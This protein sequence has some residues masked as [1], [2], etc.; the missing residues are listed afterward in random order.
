MTD[1]GEL[2]VRIKADAAQLEQEMKKANGVVRQSAGEMGDVMG[3]LKNQF[4]D[5]IPAITIAAV[6]EFGR[7]AIESAD[8]I[9]DLALRTGFAGSTLSALNIPLKQSGSSLDDFSASINRMNNLIGEAAKGTNQEAVKAFDSLGL[10]VRKLRQLSPEDQFFAIAQALG[11]M[12]DQSTMTNAGMAIFGRSFS[13]IIP[14][15]KEAGGNLRDFVEKAEAAGNTL[16]KEQLDRID[17]FGDKWTEAVEKAKLAV[18]EFTPV[19]E[20]VVKILDWVNQQHPL[21]AL[22]AAGIEIGAKSGWIDP[23]VADEAIKEAS[24]R[25]NGKIQPLKVDIKKTFSS[26]SAM[27]D[28][29]DLLRPK[30]SELKEYIANLK[31]ETAALGQN[32]RALFIARAEI[33]ASAKA[34]ADWNNHLRASKDLLPEEKA[35]V[36]AL[37]GSFY[38][39]KKAQEEN[40]R[41]ARHMKEQLSDA[42]ADIA[43]NFNSLR[44]TATS[45]I[46]AIAKEIIKLKITTPLSN[47]IIDALPN[48]SFAS[49]LPHFAEGGYNSTGGPMV[50]GDGGEPEIF[51]PGVPGTVTPFSKLGGQSVVI[52]QTFN[53]QPGRVETV[54]VAIR[55]ATPQI[56]AVTH[57]SVMQAIQSGGNESRIVGRRS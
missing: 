43:V 23:D 52:H 27:G 33:E 42:L 30:D 1:I 34:K 5:L 15:I 45:A 39:L 6:F 13:S 26:S 31:Q 9:N 16:T 46:Q 11:K 44:D 41:V 40:E 53:M 12:D 10:S 8:H 3:Q 36:D 57:A 47:S 51:T 54:G 29:T 28:N 56:A 14:L 18:A 21:T 35:N 25:V 48:F 49:L 50:V 32:E 37:A 55:Q 22:G 20:K 17:A 7:R 4:K 19:L 2:V 38:D 24:D